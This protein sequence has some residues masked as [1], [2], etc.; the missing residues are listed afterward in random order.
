MH[1]DQVEQTAITAG[2]VTYNELRRWQIALET[3]DAHG[4]F[5]ASVSMILTEGRR[6]SL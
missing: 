1:M 2:I 6:A 4:V 5:F 3:A